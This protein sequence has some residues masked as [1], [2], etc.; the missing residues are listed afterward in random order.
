V[1]SVDRDGRATDLVWERSEIAFDRCVARSLQ[2]NLRGVYGFEHGALATFE[3]A[4]ELGLRTAYDVPAPDSAFVH[5]L[6]AAELERFPE[7]RTPYRRHTAAREARRL[8]RRRA[9]WQSAD[10]VI[11]ASDFTKR[12]YADAGLDCSKVHVVPYGAPPPI[13]REAALLARPDDTPL[14]LLW[15]GTFSIRKGAHY[16]VDAWRAGALGRHARLRV[17]GAVDLPGRVLQPLPAGIELCGSIPRENL[18]S[19]YEKAD[20]LIFPTLCDGFG[21]VVTESW[22]RGVPVITTERAGAADLLRPQQNGLL[23]RAADVEAIVEIVHWCQD[24]RAELAT[25]REHAHATAVAWQ[26]S[27]Y[28]RAL[29]RT[30]REAGF[31]PAGA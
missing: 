22:S 11:A 13:S 17:F 15:A 26:W 14:T 8:A 23:I 30:L 3:R 4:H 6:L 31:F 24:H 7:L 16:L 2:P 21:M 12:S 19:E 10:I 27:D 1:G 29:A 18:L 28:R 9:E 20:A 5:D 25:M